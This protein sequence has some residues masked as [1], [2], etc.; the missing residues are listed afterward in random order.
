MTADGANQP[1]FESGWTSVVCGEDMV[2]PEGSSARTTVGS[3][4]GAFTCSVV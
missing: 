2:F 3:L 4:K 1:G